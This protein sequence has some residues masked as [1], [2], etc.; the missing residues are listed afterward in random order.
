[1]TDQ[2]SLP[3]ADSPIG[4]NAPPVTPTPI[5]FTL[6]KVWTLDHWAIYTGA[7]QEYSAAAQEAK[8]STNA[9]T[10]QF[11]GAKALV[12]N[13]VVH[14]TGIDL[15]SLTGTG[16]GTKPNPL[17]IMAAFVRYI[18]VSIEQAVNVPLEIF[19][20]ESYGITATVSVTRSLAG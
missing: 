10:S 5:V 18:S 8:E 12:E 6:P 14:I 15:L 13:G 19:L 4:E 11:V 17:A 2:P 7:M 9:F 20:S 16:T 3:T 1:M